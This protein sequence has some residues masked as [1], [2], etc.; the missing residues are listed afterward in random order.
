MRLERRET[1]PAIAL[2][3]A[4]V[5]AI[6]ASF[7][8]S[9]ILLGLSGANPVRAY[10]LLLRG[11]AGTSFAMA[12]TLARATPLMLTGLAAAVAF[13]ARLW[14]IGAEGQLY[15]GA[16]A[17]TVFG[18]GWLVLPSF[19]MIP[20][21]MA[22][23][24]LAGAMLLLGPTILKLRFGVD[25]VV[26][27]L[28]LNFIMLLLIG[29]LIEGPLKDPDGLGWPQAAP[30]LS[31]GALPKLITGLRLHAGLIIA[32]G[33][34]AFVWLINARTTLGY[35]MKAVGAAPRAAAFAGIPVTRVMLWVALLS[36]GLAGLAGYGEVA[37]LKGNLTLDLSPGF[38][39]TGIVVAMLANLH[40]IGVIATALFVATMFVGADG[41]SRALHVP[42][43]IAD[44]IVALSLLTMLVALLL[45]NYRIRR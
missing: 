1:S 18:T 43:Y 11:A 45:A 42:S 12:E 39:Y 44:V 16:L 35:A 2:P 33:A 32:L 19:L 6:V 25:E 23:S 8:L 21:L 9:S 24:A 20:L 22:V 13:R 7:A 30:I 41:M 38:G 27:T 3:L 29:L 10:G 31:Q 28:L 17:A 4:A 34:A 37:G 5:A 14:N 36:G 15:A 26:T 40:P